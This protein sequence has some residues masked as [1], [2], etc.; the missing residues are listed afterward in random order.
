M[1]GR[2]VAEVRPNG[3]QQK[4]HAT[5]DTRDYKFQ[6]TVEAFEEVATPGGAFKTFRIDAPARKTITSCGTSRCWLLR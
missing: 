1:R 5:G 2:P 4:R 6:F 3:F